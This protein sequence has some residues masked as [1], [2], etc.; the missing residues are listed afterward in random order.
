MS[1][2]PACPESIPLFLD[3]GPE[4]SLS[5]SLARP[6]LRPKAEIPAENSSTI[7]PPAREGIS[8]VVRAFQRFLLERRYPWLIGLLATALMLACLLA[9]Y[10]WVT[11]TGKDQAIGLASS[12]KANDASGANPKHHSGGW[13]SGSGS[14]NGVRSSVSGSLITVQGNDGEEFQLVTSLRQFKRLSGR[15]VGSYFITVS[16]WYCQRTMNQPP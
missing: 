6:K 13:R 9:L 5:E 4:P 8:S 14:E 11:R 10:A 2:K 15:K 1:T 12:R 3:L 7:K 16:H